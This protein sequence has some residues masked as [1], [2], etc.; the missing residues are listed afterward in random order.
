MTILPIN[1]RFHFQFVTVLCTYRVQYSTVVCAPLWI[2]FLRA[3]LLS[4]RCHRLYDTVLYCTPHFTT[5]PSLS[6]IESPK[7]GTRRGSFVCVIPTP[8]SFHILSRNYVTEETHPVPV[9]PFHFVWILCSF[10]YFYC[11]CGCGTFAKEVKHEG[12]YS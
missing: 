12:I 10:F 1:P 3:T 5:H 8:P 2:T 4:L 7:T 11:S 9:V 6:S